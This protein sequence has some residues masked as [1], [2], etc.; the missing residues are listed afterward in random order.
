VGRAAWSASKAASCI[1]VDTT[2][3]FNTAIFNTAIFNRSTVGW[4][5]HRGTV[6]DSNPL[7]KRWVS[8]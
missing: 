7:A 5:T 6:N 4:W 3:I 8:R 2:P 1:E